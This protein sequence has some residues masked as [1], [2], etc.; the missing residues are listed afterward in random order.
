MKVFQSHQ[1]LSFLFLTMIFLLTSIVFQA[2]TD[3]TQV[4]Q[5]EPEKKEK[6]AKNDIES[7]PFQIF[8]NLG[9]RF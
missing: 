6:K 4:D 8:L 3:T 9:F 5:S 7:K 2:Q 1:K